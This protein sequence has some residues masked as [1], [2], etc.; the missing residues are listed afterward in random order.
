LFSRS[1]PDSRRD[2]DLVRRQ[3]N[4]F[5]RRVKR[6]PIYEYQTSGDHH[7]DFC[8]S[9]FELLRKISE[10]ELSRCPQCNAPIKRKLS[11][12]NI[13]GSGPSLDAANV[14]KH[15]FTQYRKSSKGVY[16]KTAGKG[17]NVISDK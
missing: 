14:E 13:G 2:A 8:V 4:G 3:F 7:C 10:P 9:G 12:P 1:K 6:M 11:A 5:A 17:P 15:G 16:E